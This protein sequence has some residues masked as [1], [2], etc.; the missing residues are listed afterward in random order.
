[1]S[2]VCCAMCDEHY[3]S[4]NR[5]STSDKLP[6]ADFSQLS[7]WTADT[8][9]LSSTGHTTYVSCLLHEGISLNRGSSDE[10][11]HTHLLR[12]KGRRADFLSCKRRGCVLLPLE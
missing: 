2:N 9:L 4:H 1:M 8:A 5:H 7:S 11:R 10:W 6:I 12:G 3:T